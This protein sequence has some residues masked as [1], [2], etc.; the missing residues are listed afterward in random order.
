MQ[1][2]IVPQL[3][4]SNFR[5]RE[6]H[7]GPVTGECVFY[8]MRKISKMFQTN[9]VFAAKKLMLPE[10]GKSDS[11]LIDFTNKIYEQTAR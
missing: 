8:K 10:S 7:S 1:I 2:K 5:E 3:M 4:I 6:H 11:Y 9:F